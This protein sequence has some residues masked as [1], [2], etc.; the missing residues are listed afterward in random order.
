MPRKEITSGNWAFAE[1][2][3]QINPDVVAAYP[4][5]PSTDIIMKFAEFVANGE[6]DTN[7]VTV[8]SEHSAI[9][10]CVTA[11][12]AGA[13]VMTASSANGVALMHEIFP[14]AGCFRTP[15]VFGLVNRSVGA[16]INIH[17]DHSD[18]MAQRDYGWIHLYC[19]DAQEVYDS[20]FMAIRL[21][22]NKDVLT[23][24]F[25]C[26]DG[27]ITSHGFEPVEYLDD[28]TA[29]KFI[30]ERNPINPLLDIE[31]PVTYGSFAMSEY[32]FEIKR[33]QIEANKKALELYDG[34]AKEYE[35][36]SG[37]YYPMI[38]CYKTDDA[39]Y[40]IVVMSSAS[41]AVKDVVDEM[42]EKG[43]KVGCLRI[44]MFRPFPT[45]A[46][47]AALKGK[48]AIA[49][50]DRSLSLGG[51]APLAAEVR[52]ALYAAGELIPTNSCIYGLG[53]RDFFPQ[54]AENIFM[55]LINGNISPEEHYI[56]LLE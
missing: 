28:E 17:C 20:A 25:V 22:E 29:K 11:S 47:A 35:A 46:I 15:I 56:G 49:V 7:F 55:D 8:E 27:F 4:I 45:E 39:D 5:T 52:S 37:R 30:G 41:G 18:S 53:G 51:T 43:H 31:N 33:Q 36:I 12:A 42:R 6:V 19:E 1:A 10:A 14:I 21:S 23:P 13:R 54:Y 32:Y 44:R 50:L 3:R 38:D 24:V 40:V 48:K 34:I 2:M 26:Q 9:T 16:P